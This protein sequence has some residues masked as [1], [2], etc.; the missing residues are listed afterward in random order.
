[1]EEKPVAE[2][3]RVGAHLLTIGAT[4]RRRDEE[5]ARE[6]AGYSVKGRAACLLQGYA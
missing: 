5:I 4:W 3:T 1:M 2:A 6:H